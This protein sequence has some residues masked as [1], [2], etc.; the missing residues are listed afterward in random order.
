MKS[1]KKLGIGMMSFSFIITMIENLSKFSCGGSSGDWIKSGNICW[2]YPF[3]L[4][5]SIIN[6]ILLVL[7]CI[8]LNLLVGDK[9]EMPKT[10]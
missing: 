8:S 2:Y 4:Q 7:V 3:Q 9:N 5:L 6:F 1:E 10:S